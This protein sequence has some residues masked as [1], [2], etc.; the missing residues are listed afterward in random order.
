MSIY[1]E[2]S[3][4]SVLILRE[5]SP[6]TLIYTKRAS[7]PKRIVDR[8]NSQAARC[9]VQR[10]PRPVIRSIYPKHI[11]LFQFSI[12]QEGSAPLWR[13]F[14]SPQLP[15]YRAPRVT[16]LADPIV[17]HYTR[18]WRLNEAGEAALSSFVHHWGILGWR[19]YVA[20]SCR[21]LFKALLH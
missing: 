17:P 9:N 14:V 5:S 4:W 10:N 15:K 3:K 19:E 12:Q 16:L 8:Q 6:L 13:R 2:P 11:S 21:G 18:S 7:T 20:R 1:S